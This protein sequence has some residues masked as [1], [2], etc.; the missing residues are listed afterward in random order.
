MGTYVRFCELLVE[1][2]D[3]DAKFKQLLVGKDLK[4]AGETV[5]KYMEKNCRRH[6]N[7]V[8][9]GSVRY[10]KNGPR[11]QSMTYY[12]FPAVSSG[13]LRKIDN[14]IKLYKYLFVPAK[15]VLTTEYAYEIK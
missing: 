13:P 7:P 4:K 8:Y 1:A 5:K 6:T 12:S 9:E 15:V 3:I 14:L 11:V 2:P 10:D